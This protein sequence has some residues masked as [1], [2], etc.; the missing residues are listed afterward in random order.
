MSSV[1]TILNWKLFSMKYAFT[2]HNQ[3]KISSCIYKLK[4]T[5]SETYWKVPPPPAHLDRSEVI[6]MRIWALQHLSK[7]QHSGTSL[8]RLLW[9]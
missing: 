9:R 5:D 2:V 6:L 7:W 8:E 1:F 3:T 4:N